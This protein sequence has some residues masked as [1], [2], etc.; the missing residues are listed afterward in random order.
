MFQEE[1]QEKPNLQDALHSMCLINGVTSP[2][3]LA[4]FNSAHDL[5]TEDTAPA[6]SHQA[7]SFSEC[8]D[9]I[10]E[11]PFLLPCLMHL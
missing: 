4:I 5:R 2:M 11:A 8:R 3:T 7:M 1:E 6:P 10:P 9:G